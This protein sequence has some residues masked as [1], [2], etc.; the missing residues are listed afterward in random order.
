MGKSILK[1]RFF[2][3]SELAGDSV[4]FPEN[5]VFPDRIDQFLVTAVDQHPLK[6]FIEIKRFG[7]NMLEIPIELTT[8]RTH[9]D[10]GVGI[11]PDVI[12]GHMSRYRYPGFLLR[13]APVGQLQVR[14]IRAGNP[15]FSAGPEEVVQ[16]APGIAAGLPHFGN[17]FKL[18]QECAV[19]GVVSTD[20]A[21]LRD[22]ARAAGEA[23]YHF[24]IGYDRAR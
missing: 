22:I 14:V 3:A 18:P 10:R 21:V 16:T 8:V 6:H 17:G 4:V 24:T 19:V 15:G 11:K 5:A 20:V 9:R 1:D 2:E 23:H 7:R 13:S 12:D